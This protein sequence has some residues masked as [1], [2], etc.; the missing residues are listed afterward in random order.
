MEA[1]FQKDLLIRLRQIPHSEWF[2]KEAKSIRG[3]SDIIGTVAGKS[4]YLE[5]KRSKSE[6]NKNT[7][8]IC[9][10]QYFLDKMRAVGAYA[11]FVYPENID[12]VLN[13]LSTYTY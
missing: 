4:V 1:F 7:G 9:L 11:S 12:N 8:R 10:Q 6:A 2:V 13:D 5:V 3:I